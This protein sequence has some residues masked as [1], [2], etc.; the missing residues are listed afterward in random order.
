MIKKKHHISG[1][2]KTIIALSAVLSLA[3]C[4]SSD[5]DAI[6]DTDDYLRNWQQANAR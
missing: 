6:A 1:K 2:L 3:A 4:D 5:D